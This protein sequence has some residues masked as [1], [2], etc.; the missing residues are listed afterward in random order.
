MLAE[1]LI[2]FVGY[3]ASLC[4]IMSLIAKTD[5]KFRLWNSAG[6]LLF[7][8]YAVLIKAWPV[9][10]PNLILFVINLVFIRKLFNKKE[11]FDIVE[12]GN[13][14]KMLQ[15]FLA[16]NREDIKSYFPKFEANDMAGN[17]TFAV[18]RDLVISNVF[19]AKVQP[20][21]LAEVAINYT[22]PKYR[23]FKIGNYIFG[24]KKEVLKEKGIKTVV[25]QN[26]GH[27]GHAE[28]LRVSGFE[29]RGTGYIK[30]L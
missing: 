20:D 3:A 24:D 15:K 14:D 28:F 17:T 22:I 23:D 19:S 18:L 6:C 26:V 10:V 11:A 12:L 8:I 30:N 25:Y 9:F 13:D 7:M 5:L 16:F 27:K 4:L 2:P 29:Q 21:G 1:N